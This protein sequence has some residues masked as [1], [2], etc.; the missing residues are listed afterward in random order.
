MHCNVPRWKGLA[1]DGVGWTPV[2]QV[3]AEEGFLACYVQVQQARRGLCRT[4][5]GPHLARLPCQLTLVSSCK[6]RL[7]QSLEDLRL[8]HLS[9]LQ[10]VLWEIATGLTP[11]RGD[12]RDLR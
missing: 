8:L 2:E 7:L 4:T 6:R 1:G 12:M 11:V 5:S 3:D 10:V 9:L